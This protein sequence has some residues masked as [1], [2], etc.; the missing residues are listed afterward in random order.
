MKKGQKV[1][2]YGMGNFGEKIVRALD[3]NSK[4]IPYVI[5]AYMDKKQKNCLGH[6]VISPEIL[7]DLAYDYIVIMT[8]KYFVTIRQ[9][10]VHKYMVDAN[11]ILPWEQLAEGENYN[12]NYCGRSSSFFCTSV[13][14][15]ELNKDR[16]S[17]L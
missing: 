8:E 6:K 2:L 13:A 1:I 5:V 11:K 9:E 14:D 15:S 7:S 12:C 17:V 3:E 16:K 10:L 4:R